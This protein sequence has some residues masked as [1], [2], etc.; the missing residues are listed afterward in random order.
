MPI[1]FQLFPTTRGHSCWRC[2]RPPSRHVFLPQASRAQ[3]PRRQGKRWQ[4]PAGQ[5]TALS[6][7]SHVNSG[8][9]NLTADNHQPRPAAAFH[10]ARNRTCDPSRAGLPRKRVT[11]QKPDATL[12]QVAPPWKQHPQQE[13]LD[14]ILSMPLYSA[15]PLQPTFTGTQTKGR[16]SHTRQDSPLLPH[17]GSRHPA[18]S[19]GSA[20]PPEPAAPPAS[21]GSLHTIP[22]LE[23]RKHPP[24]PLPGG[25]YLLNV[26]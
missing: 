25:R 3:P 5:E 18:A 16:R 21:V 26:S 13:C 14:V 15:T 22:V 6:R 20:P 10:H 24:L 23:L 2:H 8:N 4:Q 17:L 7:R 1:C 9:A 12:D 11:E 19:R